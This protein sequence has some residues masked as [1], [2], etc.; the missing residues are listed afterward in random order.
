MKILGRTLRSGRREL[1]IEHL[2]CK[3][4]TV[5]KFYLLILD[6]LILLKETDFEQLL[7]VCQE[8]L[9]KILD[10]DSLKFAVP[11]KAFRLLCF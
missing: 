2:N 3:I 6:S 7:V 4:S 11:A 1:M 8:K 10:F 9:I 5:P